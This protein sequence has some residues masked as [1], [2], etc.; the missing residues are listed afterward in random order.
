MP[1]LLTSRR[2]AGEITLRAK[3]ARGERPRAI[4]VPAYPAPLGWAVIA[5]IGGLATAAASWLICAGIGVLGWSAADSATLRDAVGLGTRL[6]LLANGIGVH[7][8]TVLI[9][10]V[11]WGLTAVIAFLI[12][13][14]AG[15]SARRVPAER[16]SD[17]LAAMD[18]MR[19]FRRREG[20]VRW[21]LFRDLADPDRYLETFVVLSWGEHMR[22]HGRVTVEDQAIEARAFAFQQEGVA[23]VAAHLIAARAYNRRAP[24]APPPAELS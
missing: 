12:A 17:F 15:A 5:S 14:V 16:A 9:T 3:P 20:A 21:D 8:G 13:R 19:I 2:A 1:S 7:I 23:P 4:R 6:W 11:P 10:L 24:A 18:D 22:Q